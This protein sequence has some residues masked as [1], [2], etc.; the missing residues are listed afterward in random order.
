MLVV[1]VIKIN[2]WQKKKKKKKK[3]KNFIL[4]F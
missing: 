4:F 2:K 3:K 1:Y